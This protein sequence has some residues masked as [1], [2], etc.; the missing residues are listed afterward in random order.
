MLRGGPGHDVVD[1]SLEVAQG[2]YPDTGRDL[3]S[4]GSGGDRLDGID[5][6]GGNDGLSGGRGRDRCRADVGD[7]ILGC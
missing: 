2:V 4:G 7:D 3:L 5:E 1:D 6:V